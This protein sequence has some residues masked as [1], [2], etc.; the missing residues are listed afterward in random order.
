MPRMDGLTLM[1]KI[2]ELRPDTPI[3]LMTG[4]GDH[5]LGVQALNAGAYAFIPKP[6]DTEIFLAWLSRAIHV[7]ALS[8]D[9]QE[10][11]RRLQRHTEILEQAVQ[12]RTAHLQ[13]ALE[14]L[15]TAQH[16]NRHLAALVESS[17]DAIISTSPTGVI[18]TWNQGAEHLYG[19]TARDVI[20][21]H[22]SLLIP[23]DRQVEE[24]E[25]LARILQGER[26]PPFETDR[27]SVV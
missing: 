9:V 4:Q 17:E 24:A 19:Y 1:G 5:G 11:T 27:K 16:G 25:I 15:K 10:K 7:R 13:A 20:G 6:I 23:A 18:Q 8:R 3:L 14:A 2:H 21:R 26:V 12:E 22:I